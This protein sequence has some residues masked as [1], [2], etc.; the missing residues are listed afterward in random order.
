MPEITHMSEDQNTP[1]QQQPEKDAS[2]EV[3]T[4][5]QERLNAAVEANYVAEHPRLFPVAVSVSKTGKKTGERMIHK[6]GMEL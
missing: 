6:P 4:S 1:K 3:A 5:A 2:L